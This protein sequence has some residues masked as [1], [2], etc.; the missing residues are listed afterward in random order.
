M[1]RLLTLLVVFLSVIY[2]LWVYFSIQK[3]PPHFFG[4]LLAVIALLKYLVAP[5]K[6]SKH[7]LL[8]LLTTWF[9]AALIIFS[10]TSYAIKL[11]PVFISSFMAGLFATS[12]WDEESLIEKMAKLRGKIISPIAKVYIKKLTAI[13]SILLLLNALIALYLTF[14][15]STQAWALYSGLIAYLVFGVF[16][17]AEI[18]YRQHFIAKYESVSHQ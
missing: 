15:A 1:T 13:W 3:L 4:L 11:Y 6:T 8:L 10:N 9:C 7:E 17:A 16:I 5:D 12:L 18:I 14:F 2:P